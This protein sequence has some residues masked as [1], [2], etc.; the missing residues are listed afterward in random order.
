MPEIP[1]TNP[2]APTSILGTPC[3]TTGIGAMGATP[4]TGVASGSC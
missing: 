3:S 2:S 1:T 4:S